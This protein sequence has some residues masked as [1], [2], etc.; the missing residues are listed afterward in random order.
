MDMHLEGDKPVVRFREAQCVLGECARV[1][2]V[3]HPKFPEGSELRTSTVIRVIPCYGNVVAF[4][5][6]NTLYLLAE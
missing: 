1:I 4:E 6:L 2:A 5:T 3:D